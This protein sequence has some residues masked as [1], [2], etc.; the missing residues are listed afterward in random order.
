MFTI[1]IQNIISKTLIKNKHWAQCCELLIPALG[2]L[3][4]GDFEFMASLDYIVKVVSK[5]QR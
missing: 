4:Q 3:R 1:N 5:I 2:R